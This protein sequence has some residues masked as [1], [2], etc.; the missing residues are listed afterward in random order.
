MKEKIGVVDLA[1]T[2]TARQILKKYGDAFFDTLNE[3]YGHLDGYVP[4]VGKARKNV[5]DQ[6]ATIVNTRYL[7]FLIDENDIPMVSYYLNKEQALHAFTRDFW[8]D[9]KE[10]IIFVKDDIIINEVALDKIDDFM[11]KI[12]AAEDHCFHYL[13]IH[14]QYFYEHY[15]RYEPDYRDRIFAT[16]DW[17]HKHGYRPETLTNVALEERR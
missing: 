11:E 2:M 4:V 10:D 12:S 5:L 9:N 13:L 1:R 7:S 14:E 17:C 8:V 3:A 16:V 15:C 6:F